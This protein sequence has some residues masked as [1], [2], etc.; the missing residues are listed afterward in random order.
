M[1][2]RPGGST[3]GRR[4]IHF[5]IGGDMEVLLIAGVLILFIILLTD[6]ILKSFWV[7]KYFYS[8][9]HM[10]RREAKSIELSLIGLFNQLNKDVPE[11][12][13]LLIRFNL[14]KDNNKILFRERYFKLLQIGNYY[15]SFLH[16]T[17]E[18]KN[19]VFIINGYLGIPKILL[20]LPSIIFIAYALAYFLIHRSINIYVLLF[21]VVYIIIN[22]A[23][24]YSDYKITSNYLDKI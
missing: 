18:K 24:Y 3:A 12:K 19:D 1:R 5:M 6:S 8:G 4:P 23:L 7:E 20:A 9:V 11:T 22:A 21:I 16:G 15:H 10:Y 2:S 17:I 13:R 14:S